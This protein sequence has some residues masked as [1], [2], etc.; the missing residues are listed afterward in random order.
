MTGGQ[1]GGPTGGPPNDKKAPTEDQV[2][3][4]YKIL[5]RGG[6]NAAVQTTGTGYTSALSGTAGL[7]TYLRN[8][9]KEG[10]SSE[11]VIELYEEVKEKGKH[12]NVGGR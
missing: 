10:V 4:A 8:L 3:E 1:T 7:E 9:E 6:G 12:Y 11:K 2:A 5:Q